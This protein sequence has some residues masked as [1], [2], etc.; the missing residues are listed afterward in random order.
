[1][2][3]LTI[4]AP[5]TVAADG[6]NLLGS[7]IYTANGKR[8]LLA[9]F[10]SIPDVWSSQPVG[11]Y[12]F[13][14][15]TWVESTVTISNPNPPM[16]TVASMFL[17]PSDGKVYGVYFPADTSG[18]P[19][20][21]VTSADDGVS[22]TE[23]STIPSILASYILWNSQYSGG[24]LI[25][26]GIGSWSDYRLSILTWTG[27]VWSTLWQSIA[28]IDAP[29]YMMMTPNYFIVAGSWG[30]DRYPA[31]TMASPT[32]IYNSI[33]GYI[34]SV[35]WDA[36]L[37]QFLIADG[38]KIFESTAGETSG[39]G[40]WVEKFTITEIDAGWSV[41]AR[42]RCIQKLGNEFYAIIAKEVT[43]GG[44]PEGWVLIKRNSADGSWSLLQHWTDIQTKILS[45]ERG[46]YQYGKGMQQAGNFESK[47]IIPTHYEV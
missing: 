23:H 7:L 36:T 8:R 6:N 26:G 34:H 42:V 27:A 2:D 35:Y 19:T 30:I 11:Y 40:D 22:W 32:T 15:Q 14:T 5:Q 43:A 12:D 17:H 3:F 4:N 28:T 20:S 25:A 29:Y 16:R 46:Y 1:M 18:F 13:D 24:R 44:D 39:T 37:G 33:T 21:V 38:F 31:A 47:L 45:G 9:G 10:E 41:N